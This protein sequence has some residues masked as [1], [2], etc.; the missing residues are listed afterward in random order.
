MKKQNK[1]EIIIEKRYEF[2]L[3]LMPGND[4]MDKCYRTVIRACN[5]FEDNVAKSRNPINGYYEVFAFLNGKPLTKPR[6]K[7]IFGGKKKNIKPGK[8]WEYRKYAGD[9]NVYKFKPNK[10]WNLN[11]RT[12]C[13]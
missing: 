1:I 11:N 8:E 7:K 5:E 13:P 12:D 9:E 3:S 2:D 4:L 10:E 6:E